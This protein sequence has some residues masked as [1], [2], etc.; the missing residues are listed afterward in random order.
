[1]DGD[2][3]ISRAI[4]GGNNCQALRADNFLSPAIISIAMED[5]VYVGGKGL[6]GYVLAVVLRFSRGAERVTLRARGR[7][8]ARAV[9]AAEVARRLLGGAVELGGVR[10]ASEAVSG[11]GRERLVSA[12]EI[13]LVRAAPRTVT[14]R[15]RRKPGS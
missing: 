1:M 4:T 7:H 9:D 10:I 15:R 13:T 6:A 11:G 5:C 14:R 12:I 3:S 2:I 8:V